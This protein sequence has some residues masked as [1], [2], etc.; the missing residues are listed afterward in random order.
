MIAG[1]VQSNGAGYESD[2]IAAAGGSL[3]AAEQ[4]AA[5]LPNPPTTAS[6]A[7]R[8]AVSCRKAASNRRSAL[9][10]DIFALRPS[11]VVNDDVFD[12]F[13]VVGRYRQMTEKRCPALYRGIYGQ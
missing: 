12:G 3:A 5:I 13:F 6:S 10:P 1:I 8:F 7:R 4:S 2:A 9:L 11:S